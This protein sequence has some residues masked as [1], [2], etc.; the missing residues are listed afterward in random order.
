VGKVVGLMKMLCR[1]RSGVTVDTSCI[2]P[3]LCILIPASIC[4]T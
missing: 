3:F 4:V 1:I 2:S